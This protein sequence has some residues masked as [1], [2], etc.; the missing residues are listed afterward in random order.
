MQVRGDWAFATFKPAQRDF[1]DTKLRGE[2]WLSEVLSRAPCFEF[3]GGQGS[4]P[5]A[6]SI[7]ASAMSWTASSSRFAGV[8][9]SSSETFS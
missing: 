2:G 9:L 7:A 4:R 1:V 5:S 6:L 3:G 8:S